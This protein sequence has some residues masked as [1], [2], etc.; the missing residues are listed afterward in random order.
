MKALVLTYDRNRCLTDQMIHRYRQLWPDHPFTFRIPYQ[1]DAGHGED[2]REYI[3]SPEDI[4]GTVLTL[5]SDIDDAEWIYWCIDDKYPI[6]LDLPRIRSV[7]E[8]VEGIS[9]PTLGGVLFCRPDRLLKKKFLTGKTLRD[10]Q[11]M[12]YL[13]RR[14]YKKIWIHQLMRAGT[15]RHLFNSFPDDIPTAKMMD[16]HKDAVTKPVHHRL[17]VSTRN[18]AVF[19]ESSYRGML[20]KNCYR[21]MTASNIR[22]P[23]WHTVFT[24]K[25]I[26]I[27]KMPSDLMRTLRN[28][29]LLRAW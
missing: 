4:K 5:L 19:G 16:M 7:F 18:L 26:L 11:G 14:H 12:K 21:S 15:L 20:T 8:W 2:D 24:D 3:P 17:F 23:E 29:F 10:Y 6:E 22:I 1:R 27:G 13:E 25:E 9:D 28:L